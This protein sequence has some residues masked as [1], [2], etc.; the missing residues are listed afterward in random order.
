MPAA[1]G[2]RD[3]EPQSLRGSAPRRFSFVRGCRSANLLDGTIGT[4]PEL[5]T[6]TMRSPP[7][8]GPSLSM[9]RPARSS[10]LAGIEAGRGLAALLVLGVHLRDHL[11][12]NFGVPIPIG[13]WFI[14]GHAGVEFF[15][16]LSGFIIFHVHECDIGHPARLWHYLQRRF[17]RIYP[18]YWIMLLAALVSLGIS[19]HHGLPSVLRTFLSSLLLPGHKPILPV[20][21]TLQHEILFYAIFAI[22]ILNKRIGAGAVILWFVLCALNL[23]EAMT[24][25]LGAFNLE[26]GAGMAAAWL[27]RRATIPAPWLFVA[28][29][30]MIFFGIGCVEDLALL[31]PRTFPP[32]FG[33]T[34]G[35]MLAILG[36]VELERSGRLVVPALPTMLGSASYAIYLAHLLIIGAIWY[37]LKFLGLTGT[38]PLWLYFVGMFVVTAAVGVALSRYI[39]QPLI[40]LVR[41][42]F[43]TAGRRR[44]ALAAGE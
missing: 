3:P 15:F 21:W 14:F 11:F 24:P 40:A 22:L 19:F 44:A 5:Q 2:L 32:H 16:V 34:I 27:L 10:R 8:V 30:V 33:Y 26:F 13:D 23:V 43:E 28:A 38:F 29:G 41:R 6:Q 35:S 36:L 18:F 17:S 39:E 7:S 25:V 1:W 37:G 31:A 20:A 4:R 9:A 12:K 42:W